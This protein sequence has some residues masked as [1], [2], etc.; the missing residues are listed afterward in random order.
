LKWNSATATNGAPA[1]YRTCFQLDHAPESGATYRFGTDGL[2]FGNLWLN[3]HNVG[4]YPE[5]LKGCPGLWLPIC[6]MKPGLNMLVIYDERGFAPVK[7]TVKLEA[8]ASRHQLTV[9]Q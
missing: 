6:W 2:S 1:Y 3:G 5:I 4:R 9:I 8:E 7:T